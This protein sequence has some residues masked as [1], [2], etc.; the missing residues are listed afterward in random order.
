VGLL[1]GGIMSEFKS[2]P[3]TSMTLIFAVVLLV[4]N[5]HEHANATDVSTVR[6][7]VKS[8]AEAVTDI[9]AAQIEDKLIAAKIRYCQS[10]KAG[11]EAQKHYFDE[12]VREYQ[13]QYRKVTSRIY[14]PP[15]CN[16][17]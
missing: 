14:L 15:T 6:M 9:R 17:V 7:E 5:T 11:D 8:V 2:H 16:E 3:W 4:W 13:E 10:L 12:Q 1:A